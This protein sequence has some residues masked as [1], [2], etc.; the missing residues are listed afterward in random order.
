MARKVG[1]VS[2]ALEGFR[3]EVRM[4][5]DE[6]V[7]RA[8]HEALRKAGIGR[9][10]VDAVAVSSVDA[11]DGITISNGLTAPAGGGYEKD[12]TRIQGGGLAA[13]LSAYASIRSGAAE[14]AIV[15][16]GDAVQYDDAVISNASYDVHFNRGTGITNIQSCA[17]VAASL[18]D[19]GVAT[20]K[21]FALV[22]A[23][24]YCAGMTNPHAH[25]TSG[26]SYDEV[27][28]SP[29]LSWPLRSLEVAPISKGSAALVLAS[30]EAAR[31]MGADPVWITGLA[32]GTN[33]YAGNWRDLVAMKGLRKA[34]RDAYEAAGVANP[35]A[36]I[37]VF[38]LYTP[39]APL[40]LAYYELL[41]LCRKG[42]AAALLKIGG[43]SP[44]TDIEANPY[45]VKVREREIAINPSGGA[46]CTNPGNCGGIYR[47]ACV[48]EYL[49]KNGHVRRGVVQDSDVNLGFM[50]ETYHVMIL[51][52]ETR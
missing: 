27:A 32:G 37:D 34:I 40:E 5:S 18:L 8:V 46:L 6:L 31:E 11:Y 38:E 7:F 10:R 36:D 14:V 25:V 52:K 13:V 19:E 2:Y 24:N 4:S 12:A 47:A 17:L 48:L 15:A 16:G 26:Y 9:D 49:K 41:G 35:A 42:E 29:M 23:K 20:E 50:G 43:G 44:R 33:A 28:A 3:G 1:I 39:A 21:D 51:E 22:A 30:E 45:G